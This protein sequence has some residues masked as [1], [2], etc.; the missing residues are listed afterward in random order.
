MAQ[1][2]SENTVFSTCV[3]SFSKL[4]NTIKIQNKIHNG[5]LY[6]HTLFTHLWIAKWGTRII[7]YINVDR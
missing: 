1:E 7:T 5:E 4:V 6:I 3:V 2:L